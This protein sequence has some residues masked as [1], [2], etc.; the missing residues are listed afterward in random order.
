M[1]VST[2]S[3]AVPGNEAKLQQLQSVEHYGFT[4]DYIRTVYTHAPCVLASFPGPHAKRGEGLVTIGKIPICAEL[5]S[6]D[7]G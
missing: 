5:S 6:L 4:Y 1:P 7:F 3:W 2:K